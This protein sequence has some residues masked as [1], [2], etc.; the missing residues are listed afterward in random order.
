M[1]S[2]IMFDYEQVLLG[3]KKFVSSYY[4]SYTGRVNQK[5][6]LELFRYAIEYYLDWSPEDAQNYLTMDIIK[7]LKLEGIVGYIQFPPELNP[8]KDFF[9]IA[10][11]LYPDEIEWDEYEL[12]LNVYHR[13]LR[14]E[15]KKFPKEYLSEAEGILRACVCLQYMLIQFFSNKFS[16][17]KD[18]Y[19]MFSTSDG[20]AALKQYR[21][22]TAYCDIYDNPVD[23]LHNSLSDLQKS[24]FFHQFYKFKVELL[25]VRKE[26]KAG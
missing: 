20:I 1:D 22:Y 9:Y 13:I 18:I 11:L 16:T 8:N 24:E 23:Y 4:F 3:K 17:V 12:T 14:G 10:Y 21:L 25:G 7:Q 6:A 5:N 26:Q 15:L 2:G 19:Y